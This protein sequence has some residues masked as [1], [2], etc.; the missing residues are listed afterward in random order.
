MLVDW[1]VVTIKASQDR[2][3]VRATPGRFLPG[4][5]QGRGHLVDRLDVVPDRFLLGTHQVQTPVDAGRQPTQLRL[6]EPPFFAATLRSIDCRTSS[7]ASA[8]RKPGG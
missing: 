2:V 1:I 3:E 6:R 5:V 8:I 7:N 4:R